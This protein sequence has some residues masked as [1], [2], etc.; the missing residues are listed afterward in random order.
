MIKCYD[1]ANIKNE[2]P[3]YHIDLTKINVQ[4]SSIVL[5]SGGLLDE[6]NK[7]VFSIPD[8]KLVFSVS[9]RKGR[10]EWIK[11]IQFLHKKAHS[12]NKSIAIPWYLRVSGKSEAKLREISPEYILNLISEDT[13]I[14]AKFFKVLACQQVWIDFGIM[15][16]KKPNILPRTNSLIMFGKTTEVA[17][18]ES[19]K[20]GINFPL[21]MKTTAKK[22]TNKD[23]LIN[24]TDEQ[25]SSIDNWI[26][27]STEKQILLDGAKITLHA[28]DDIICGDKPPGRWFYIIESGSC[29]V[30][31][32]GQIID[33]L[34]PKTIFGV[35]SF[36]SS[37]KNS[38]VQ[39]IA[40]EN[41]TKIHK[42]EG[43][44]VDILF[45]YNPNL[46]IRFYLY[47]SIKCAKKLCASHDWD[48]MTSPVRSPTPV[49]SPISKA[50][51]PEKENVNQNTLTNL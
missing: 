36:F 3:D 8:L 26:W 2:A 11:N 42:I 25:T 5:V 15:K 45:A 31:E 32:R 29:H 39:I 24:Q 10:E 51:H 38:G 41:Q 28:K 37:G 12:K 49:P 44:Y 18:D 34:K 4:T 23:A 9:T 6:S 47:Y 21:K 46:S 33:T 40:A 50:G 30:I 7:F 35:E 1:I 14:G 27:T 19:K 16:K 20:K 43:Y 48:V 17:R 22:T 13:A